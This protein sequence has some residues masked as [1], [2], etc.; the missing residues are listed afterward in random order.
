M[1]ADVAVVTQQEASRVGG[2]PACL[3]HRALQ[4]PPALV[5]NYLCDLQE[6]EANHGSQSSFLYMI[7]ITNR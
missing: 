4:A 1:I 7:N 3:A 5:K 2:L 6:E